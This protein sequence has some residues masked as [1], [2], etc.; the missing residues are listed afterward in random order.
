MNLFA[1]RSTDPQKLTTAADPFGPGNSDHIIR[2]CTAAG[3]VVV[4]W[5][6]AKIAIGP[7]KFLTSFLTEHRVRLH[8]LGKTKEGFP[9][10]PLYVPAATKPEPWG[11]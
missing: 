10:H 8:C 11:V 7:G 2:A 9:R 5:G 4:A 1:F 3:I 6:A